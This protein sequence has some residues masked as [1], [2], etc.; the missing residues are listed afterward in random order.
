MRNRRLI[1]TAA[2]IAAGVGLVPGMA[3][4]ADP[5]KPTKSVK[6]DTHEVEIAPDLTKAAAHNFATFQSPAE[7]TVQTSPGAKAAAPQGQGLAGSQPSV[8]LKGRGTSAHGIS[9]AATVTSDPGTPLGVYVEWGDGTTN[10]IGANGPETVTLDHTYAKVGHYKITVSLVDSS[11]TRAVNEMD[12]WTPGSDFT[13][14]T[15]TRLLDTREGT[16][17][18]KGKV[19]ASGTARVQIEGNSGIPANVTAVVLNVTVTNATGTGYVT[20][21]GDGDA[22]PDSS[23]L[24]YNA[25]QTVPN[26][27]IVPVGSNGYVNLFNYGGSVDL[28]ADVTG[29]FTRTSSS[30]YTPL[31]PNRLVDTRSGLGA[32]QGQ[33][34]GLGTFGVQVHGRG[35]VPSSAKAVALNVTVTEPRSN[36][37]LS[38]FPGGQQASA[39]SNLNFTT[40][41]TVANAVIVPIGSDGKIS[42][43]N[44]SWN[45]AD[46][47][48]D[49]VGYYSPDSQ[50]AYLPVLPERLLDTRGDAHWNYGPLED[51]EYA[52]MP[53][54]YGRPNETSWV[55]NT[56]VTNTTNS[57]WLGVA[58]DPNSLDAYKNQYAV[59][60][61]TP[62][63][64]TL[65]WTRGK[66]VPNLVQATGG[67]DGIVDLFNQSYGSTHLVV[68]IF[69]YYDKS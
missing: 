54:G 14:H 59:W 27:V 21:F 57:G 6:P 29:Y 18:P 34:P 31:T 62:A 53:L 51:F 26:L 60:P 19:P 46:V 55:L 4:A 24:N 63:S 13:P 25:G 64:S 44:G 15:P 30:G 11:G 48:V 37:F 2:V 68:D 7:R 10:Q 36:G 49:V 28:V 5:V 23:N 16:G 32:R 50:S 38:V 47:I 67:P 56:T 65:N 8:S 20:A 58:P 41:Q 39:T 3:H 17:A 35:G 45:P 42:V 1:A 12:V 61:P 33:V 22:K 52:Y 69:G 9:L 40:G 43:R 66:V